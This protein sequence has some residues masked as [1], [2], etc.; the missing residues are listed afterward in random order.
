MKRGGFY[1]YTARIHI[2]FTRAAYS[3]GAAGFS[4]PDRL[5]GL[6]PAAPL[7]R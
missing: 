1:K 3:R 2:D 4:P 7:I 6:K 5:G